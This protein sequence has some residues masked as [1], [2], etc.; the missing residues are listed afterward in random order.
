MPGAIVKALL[1]MLP[2]L[3]C[4]VIARAQ[5]GESSAAGTAPRAEVAVYG[6]E[7]VASYA[8]NPASFTQG[9]LW[10]KGELYEGTGR[11]GESA[12]MKLDLDSGEVKQRIPLSAR[13][14]G[15]GIAVAG[16]RLFQLT[17]RENTIFEYDVASLER[18]N[19]HYLATEGWG[20]TWDGQHL[21]VSDG[22]DRLFF[23][24]P[25]TLVPDRVQSVRLNGQAVR[26]LNE[27]E[28]INGEVWA[29]V[30]MSEQIVTIHPE[31]GQVT[32]VIDLRGLREEAGIRQRDGVLNGIAWDED[33]NRLFVTGKLWPKLFEIRIPG[34]DAI[35]Q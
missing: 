24:D 17:W 5:S 9:L 8:H 22:S 23:L 26:N 34:M 20:V 32:A 1:W 35:G 33:S 4:A 14:F 16:E 2:M 30:W 25:E 29:N 10:H 12:L 13:F 28:F 18:V 19:S 27:L 7:V 3:L 11:Y 31:S 6:Y 21:I 15:E